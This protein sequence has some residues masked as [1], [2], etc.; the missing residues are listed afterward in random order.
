MSLCTFF[1][2]KTKTFIG[3]KLYWKMQT[4]ESY[5]PDNN[6]FTKGKKDIPFIIN[7]WK[8]CDMQK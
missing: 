3:V 7:I 1:N 5:C 6:N 2:R 4:K 8:T